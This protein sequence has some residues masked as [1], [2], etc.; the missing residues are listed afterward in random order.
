MEIHTHRDLIVWRRAMEFA[1]EV[2]GLK[3][4]F[5]P[6]EGMDVWRQLLRAAMSIPS[7]IAEGAGR[8]HRG[9]YLRFI[10]IARGSLLEADSHLAMAVAFGYLRLEDVRR[11]E[12][13]SIE[14][15]KM[16]SKLASV[17]ARDPSIRSPM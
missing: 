4:R 3:K 2:H 13:L 11:A 12:E 8:K 15:F 7:N 6:R 17:L 16:L 14:V 10:S 5:P 1:A 9:D